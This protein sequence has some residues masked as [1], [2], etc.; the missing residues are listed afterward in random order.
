MYIIESTFHKISI[1]CSCLR[2]VPAKARP[3]SLTNPV[4][5]VGKKSQI[6]RWVAARTFGPFLPTLYNPCDSNLVDIVYRFMISAIRP[7]SSWFIARNVRIA[8][9]YRSDNIDLCAEQMFSRH[10]NRLW[11]K[12]ELSSHQ[13]MGSSRPTI[14]DTC[15]RL[16]PNREVR[17]SAAELSSEEW[18]RMA[19]APG[20]N[21]KMGKIPWIA[22]APTI[23]RSLFT[24]STDLC[25]VCAIDRRLF[26]K[27][28][29]S[30]VVKNELAKNVPIN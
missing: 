10:W 2:W 14:K 6:K 13:E 4:Y 9:E 12:T 30:L 26:D 3:F 24:C 28:M 22:I 5:R 7:I 29:T 1:T 21:A 11:P 19:K 23:F 18:A 16:N 17:P 25:N 15:S 27:K 20:T 8:I